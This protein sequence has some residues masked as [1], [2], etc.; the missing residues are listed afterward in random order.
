MWQITA[1]ALPVELP[2]GVAVL[3]GLAV[4]CLL[5]QTCRSLLLMLSVVQVAAAVVTCC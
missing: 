4:V 1:A 5:Q 2:A 3:P